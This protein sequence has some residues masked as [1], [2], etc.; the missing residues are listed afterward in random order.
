MSKSPPYNILLIESDASG[1]KEALEMRNH[2]VSF[3][4]SGHEAVKILKNNLNEAYDVVI[5]DLEVS[6][7]TG[8]EVLS[9]YTHNTIT[10]NIPII[11][12]TGFDDETTEVQALNSGADDFI[13]KPCSP[14][15]LLA[16]IEANIRKKLAANLIEIEL[17]FCDRKTESLSK[18]ELEILEFVIKGYTNKEIANRTFITTLTVAN[19]IK[20]IFRKLNVNNRTQAVI[21]A[22]KNNL[23]N[24]VHN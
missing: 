14:K 10:K 5:L 15:K 13:V 22:L 11:V 12:F 17:P 1:V 8:W 4:N 6:G 9:K 21:F 7:I 18:R 19:H 23:I 24:L 2:N 16:R 20:R 3:V